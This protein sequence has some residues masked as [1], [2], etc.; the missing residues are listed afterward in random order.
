MITEYKQ[1]IGLNRGFLGTGGFN[2]DLLSGVNNVYSLKF[3]L[4][5]V[6]FMLLHFLLEP[7]PWNIASLSMLLI[8]PQMLLWYFIL[9][10]SVAGMI[11]MCRIGRASRIFSPLA[12]LIIYTVVIGT[13]ISNI[14]TASRF[15]DTISPIVV[16]LA[17]CALV[18]SSKYQIQHR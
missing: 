14:G 9:F 17:S 8:F 15:R 1:A 6:F 12:F 16:M 10:A 18:S 7:L 13:A 5:Y 4:K 2:Y 11:R 3:F